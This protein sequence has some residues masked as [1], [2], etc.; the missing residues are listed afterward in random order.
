MVFEIWSTESRNL[1]ASF[2]TEEEALRFVSVTLERSGAN[3]VAGL[4]LAREDESG[5]IETIAFGHHLAR[6]AKAHHDEQT[7]P[8]AIARTA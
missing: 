1:V 4:A 7:V 6:R 8:G 5:Q 3:A 2:D